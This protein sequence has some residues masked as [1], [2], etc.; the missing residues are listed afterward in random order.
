MTDQTAT[1]PKETQIAR[2]ESKRSLKTFMSETD[3]FKTFYQRLMMLP[4]IMDLYI[5]YEKQLPAKANYWHLFDLERIMIMP[6][7]SL[8]IDEKQL[9]ED[10]SQSKQIMIK[11]HQHTL[12]LDHLQ[13]A[14]SLIRRKKK[15]DFAKHKN[16]LAA[17]D[18]SGIVM[19]EFIFE[20]HPYSGEAYYAE[21]RY[22]HDG[23]ITWHDKHRPPFIFDAA[24]NNNRPVHGYHHKAAKL[25][26]DLTLDKIGLTSLQ[27]FFINLFSRQ[28]KDLESCLTYFKEHVRG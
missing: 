21:R 13:R 27:T 2:S 26:Q 15:P 3:M 10:A 17:M 4:K 19:F 18:T 11:K 1:I 20:T 28:F 16:K 22:E 23:Y 9:F 25:W 14:A 12:G 24:D 7:Q 8:H 5:R 6:D